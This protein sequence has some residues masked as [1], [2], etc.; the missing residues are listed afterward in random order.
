MKSGSLLAQGTAEEIKQNK[1][2]KEHYL[3]DGFSF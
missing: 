1:D 3:G 2:V